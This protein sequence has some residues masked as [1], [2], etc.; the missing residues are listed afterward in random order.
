MHINPLLAT[1]FNLYLSRSG[2]SAEVRNGRVGRGHTTRKACVE[3][4]CFLVGPVKALKRAFSE[5][6]VPKL[7]R[8]REAQRQEG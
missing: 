5:M 4:V 3:R 7:G 8:C 6:V 2:A 1:H